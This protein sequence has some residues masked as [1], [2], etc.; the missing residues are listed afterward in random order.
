ME[1]NKF[2]KEKKG[3]DKRIVNL[4]LTYHVGK[5]FHEEKKL[6]KRKDMILQ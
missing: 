2:S 4:R 3:H 5:M 1:K 6:H